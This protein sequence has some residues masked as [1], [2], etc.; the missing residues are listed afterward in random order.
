MSVTQSIKNRSFET[1]VQAV[2]STLKA[3]GAELTL[4]SYMYPCGVDVSN[5]SS[6][7][8]SKL[9][10]RCKNKIEEGDESDSDHQTLLSTIILNW[11][12]PKSDWI[13]FSN[14][15]PN[16]S[17]IGTKVIDLVMKKY[18]KKGSQPV[19]EFRSEMHAKQRDG[20]T[21]VDVWQRIKRNA[22][23]LRNA[24]RTIETMDLADA[25]KRSQHPEHVH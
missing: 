23:G 24:N 1:W 10:G 22:Q 5:P 15:P 25:L 11:T 18:K 21:C 14:I 9:E 17:C 6:S 12:D 3:V 8:S 7:L 19:E 13:L 4:P 20:E 2:V 16:D